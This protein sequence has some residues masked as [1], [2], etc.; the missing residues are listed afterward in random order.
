MKQGARLPNGEYAPAPTN[1]YQDALSSLKIREIVSTESG[2][3]VIGNGLKTCPICGH[4]DCFKFIPNSEAFI[5]FS[6]ECGAKGNVASFIMH[7]KDFNYTQ[8][9]RYLLDSYLSN[10]STNTSN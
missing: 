7:L 1:E 4:H 8:A 2:H 5:C 9:S 6:S 10:E 3:R